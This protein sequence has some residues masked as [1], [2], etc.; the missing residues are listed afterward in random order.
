MSPDNFSS[1]TFPCSPGLAPGL[2]TEP[3]ETPGRGPVFYPSVN[4]NH[5]M[6]YKCC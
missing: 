3:Q 5:A 1:F 6:M 2:E 4:G